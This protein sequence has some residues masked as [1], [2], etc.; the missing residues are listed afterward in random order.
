MLD[1]KVME[2]KKEAMKEFV[3]EHYYGLTV[4]AIYGAYA[5]IIGYYVIKGHKLRKVWKVAKTALDEDRTD[6][7]F[8]PYKVV[9]FFE[10]KTGEKIGRTLY[11]EKGMKD[12]L[13][14]KVK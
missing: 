2:E 12:V 14:F 5:G 7:D 9:E 4:G 11:H 8:G 10:P 3:K 13:K 1:K 6:V